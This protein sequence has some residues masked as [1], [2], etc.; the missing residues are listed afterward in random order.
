[1]KEQE[2]ELWGCTH[3]TFPTSIRRPY[4]R[5]YSLCEIWE[6]DFHLGLG[7][8]HH[9]YSR[10]VVLRGDV[11]V[12][13]SHRLLVHCPHRRDI[14]CASWQFRTF[15]WLAISS[16]AGVGG[17]GLFCMLSSSPKA[18]SMPG[19]L[20]PDPVRLQSDKKVLAWLTAMTW[21]TTQ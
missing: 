17:G 13:P 18:G 2:A 5:S 21:P 3:T 15:R 9:R 12:I 16:L 6:D 7:K 1:M 4:S 20:S 10:L 14:V 19:G 11:V 8:N